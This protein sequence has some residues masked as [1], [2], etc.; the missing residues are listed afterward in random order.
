MSSAPKHRVVIV[1]GGFGGLNAARYLRRAPVEVTLIDRRN[2]H[3]FQ[4]LLYQVATGALSPANIAAPLRWILERQANCKVLL[5]EVRDFDVADREVLLTEVFRVPPPCG[6]PS[7][8]PPPWGEGRGGGHPPSQVSNPQRGNDRI[9]YDT[10]IVA[11]GGRHSYFGHPEWEP[12]APGLKTIEDATEIRRR[13]FTAFELAEREADIGRRRM[14]LTIVIVG[15]GPTGVE[16]AGAAAE[17]ARHSLSHEFRH[18]D[19]ADAQILLVEAG[20]RV[21]GTYPPELSAKAQDSLERLGVTVRTKTMVKAITS[22]LVTVEWAG[23]R[24]EIACQTVIW[25]AGVEASPLAQRLAAA[26][27]ATLDRAGRLAVEADLSLPGRPEIFVLGDMATYAH[28][29]G[30]PLPGIAPVAIQQGR[31]VAKLIRARLRNKRPP[32]FHYRDRGTLA[33]IGRSAAVADFGK[34]RFSG[35]FA[36][37]LWLIVHL[38]NLVSF[39]NRLL[40]FIQWGWNYVTYDRAARLITGESAD[41]GPPSHTPNVASDAGR[42]LNAGA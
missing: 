42:K 4:P 20:D 19:P 8:F 25:A 15:G 3:L 21:L 22:N 7:T 13:I 11:A 38:M 2:F 23:G 37:F 33:T 30:K 29:D 36:W 5:G 26:T 40:V 31:Y 39:R 28:Q 27:G 17:I 41:T 12:L 18:I 34:L 16:M 9:K 14:L 35:F 6:D 32:V 1:G 10:L 24:D